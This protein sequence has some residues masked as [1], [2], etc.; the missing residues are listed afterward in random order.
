MVTSLPNPL[1]AT[2]DSLAR[3][4][5]IEALCDRTREIPLTYSTHVPFCGSERLLSEYLTFDLSHRRSSDSV[6][7][8][9]SSAIAYG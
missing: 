1:S 8:L 3:A 7:Q 2:E 6:E 5:I 9:F 4:E